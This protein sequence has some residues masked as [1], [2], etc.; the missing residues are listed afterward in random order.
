MLRTKCILRKTKRGNV[1]HTVR[2]HYLRND[3][4]CGVVECDGCAAFSGPAFAKPVLSAS[5]RAS[6]A[7]TPQFIVIDTSIAIHQVHAP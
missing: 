5:P 6:D 7:R 3:I 2:E 4:G 1:V